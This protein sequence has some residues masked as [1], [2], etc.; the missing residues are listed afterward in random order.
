M[1]YKYIKYPEIPHLALVPEI[2]NQNVKIFEKLDGGNCQLR[3]IN[4]R[5]LCGSRAH[6]IDDK[7]KSRVWW[8]S[9]FLHWA[10]ANKSLYNMPEE[11]V[12]FGE[13]LAKHTLEYKLENQDKFYM[14]D[15]FDLNTERFL[16]YDDAIQ[17][18]K[19]YELKD[20]NIL[21]TL[22]QGK[23]S[24]E[25]IKKLTQKSSYRDG[26]PEG[27]VV[28]DYPNQRFAKLWTRSIKTEGDLYSEYLQQA[29]FSI[30]ESGRPL[31]RKLLEKEVRKNLENQ[32]I[33][34]NENA[35]RNFIE[36]NY[37]SLI[38]KLPNSRKE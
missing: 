3:K 32:K 24:F 13:W 34:Y 2:L 38:N 22:L 7:N 18:V 17:L 33:N 36:A 1:I 11:I 5:V 21:R 19:K 27:V 23:V 37:S 15:I 25:E 14:L 31:N 16:D 29:F 28:K 4:Y 26:P 10:M 8:F 6:Y 35:L 30:L 20:I 9:D 12:I